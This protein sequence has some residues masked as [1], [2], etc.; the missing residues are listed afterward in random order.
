MT[1]PTDRPAKRAYDAA[2]EALIDH[3]VAC[4]T[5]R[6][7]G[8]QLSC[9]IARPLIQAENAAWREYR[10]ESESNPPA[11]AARRAPERSE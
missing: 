2:A 11:G 4:L 9:P 8:L 7:R 5:C 1:A 10:R 3:A 6:S